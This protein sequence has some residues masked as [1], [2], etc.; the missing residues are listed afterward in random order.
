VVATKPVAAKQ[1]MTDL[2][3]MAPLLITSANRRLY[4]ETQPFV[5]STTRAERRRFAN[6]GKLLKLLTAV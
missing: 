3:N 4:W 6:I 2:G 5:L 1:A